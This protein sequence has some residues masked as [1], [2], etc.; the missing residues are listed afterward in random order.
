MPA[1]LLVDAADRAVT[2]SRQTPITPCTGGASYA[3]ALSC[4]CGAYAWQFSL[5]VFS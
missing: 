3:D 2:A 5:Y 4:A 1:M